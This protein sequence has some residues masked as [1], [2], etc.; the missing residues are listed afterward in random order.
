MCYHSY[1]SFVT[2]QRL[3]SVLFGDFL[4]YVIPWSTGIYTWWIMTSYSLSRY[5]VFHKCIRIKFNKYLQYYLWYPVEKRPTWKVL[6][7]FCCIGTDSPLD[8]N[9]VWPLGKKLGLANARDGVSGSSTSDGSLIDFICTV[10]WFK[11]PNIL[12]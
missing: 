6:R 5:L 4:S 10:F 11:L 3:K 7:T 1:C 9:T 12:N 8:L 2:P